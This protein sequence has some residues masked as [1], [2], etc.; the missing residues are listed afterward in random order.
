MHRVFSFLLAVLA[1]AALMLSLWPAS[2]RAQHVDPIIVSGSNDELAALNKRVGE[3]MNAGDFEA[4]YVS[5]RR[6]SEIA[7]GEWSRDILEEPSLNLA[8]ILCYH[9]GECTEAVALLETVVEL[10]SEEIGPNS[11]EVAE[12]LLSAAAAMRRAWG[13][14]TIEA[15]QHI[16]QAKSILGALDLADNPEY[17]D[18]IARAERSLPVKADEYTKIE[19]D[20]RNGSWPLENV[21]ETYQRAIELYQAGDDYGASRDFALAV[22]AMRRTEGVPPE[23]I[24]LALLN[25]GTVLNRLQRSDR[26]VAVLEEAETL[27]VAVKPQNTEALVSAYRQ[28]AAAYFGKG[29][30]DLAQET[31]GR[32]NELAV[33]LKDRV[34][35]RLDA[36]VLMQIGELQHSQQLFDDAIQTYGLACQK[37]EIAGTQKLFDLANCKFRLAAVTA[38]VDQRLRLLEEAYAIQ[39]ELLPPASA[40]FWDVVNLLGQLH[41][42]QLDYA[43]AAPFYAER[44]EIA[45]ASGAQVRDLFVLLYECAAVHMKAGRLDDAA[46]MVERSRALRTTLAP[47]E[48]HNEGDELSERLL[49]SVYALQG[50]YDE[51]VGVLEAISDLDDQRRLD[52]SGKPPRSAKKAYDPIPFLTDAEGLSL[53]VSL[54]GGGR[55]QD[56]D[57]ASD[58]LKKAFRTA[59]AAVFSGASDAVMLMANRASQRDPERARLLRELQELEAHRDELH[60]FWADRSRAAEIDK[61]LI[62]RTPEIE[63]TAERI[64]VVKSILE[65]KDLEYANRAALSY[66]NVEEVQAALRED[67]LLLFYF[68]STDGYLPL[69]TYV[70]AI[71]KDSAEWTRLSVG[72]A[73]V[74]ERVANLRSLAG[75]SGPGRGAVPAQAIATRDDD[76][77]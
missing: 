6:A 35:T 24:A 36:E 59:Q 11:V 13:E 64:E 8:E 34:D 15:A 68:D 75:L 48:Y 67:D 57:G 7:N 53:L 2:A 3:L 72:P 22:A 4:A 58:I 77:F 71:S 32:A 40:G 60:N 28:L 14:N 41:V 44:V 73:E 23:Q 56:R 47:E 25:F 49:A 65:F 69:A 38:V 61:I 21:E 62:E 17:L 37:F 55:T 50:R 54:Y 46:A 20:V 51:A 70:W 27:L 16:A 12:E 26:A 19:D 31:Q 74:Q 5:A 18:L 9:R 30:Y 1:G 76:F 63:R 10:R 66:V 29:R 45:Y 42:E 39:R 43:G 52:A 33:A